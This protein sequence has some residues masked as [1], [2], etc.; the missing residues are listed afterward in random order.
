MPSDSTPR[1]LVVV[2]PGFSSLSICKWQP[3]LDRLKK[4]QEY[5]NAHFF[6]SDHGNLSRIGLGTLETLAVTLRARIDQEW[7]SNDFD[8]LVIIG[9]SMGGTIARQAYLMASGSVQ[10]CHTSQWAN[11]VVRIV[12][13]ASINRGIDLNPWD[14]RAARW[15]WSKYPLAFSAW[16]LRICQ[17]RHLFLL[18]D[19]LRGSA[20]ITNLRINWIRHTIQGSASQRQPHLVQVLG[21][22]DSLVTRSD[23]Q[24]ILA[25]PNCGW[26]DVADANHT[27][28]YS[29]SDSKNP[30]GRYNLLRQAFLGDPPNQ[31]STFTSK[32]EVKRLVFILHGIRDNN[33]ARWNKDLADTINKLSSGNVKV[34]S[35]TYNYLSAARFA[36]PTTRKKYIP[37]FQDWYTE[38][39]AA[40]PNASIGVIAHSNGTYILA[41]SL[42]EVS[43]LTVNDVFLAGSVLPQ[44]F[45]WDFIIGVKKQCQRVWNNRSV[46]DIPVGYLCNLLRGMLMLDIGTGGYSGFSSLY[47][48]ETA[49][50]EGGHSAAIDPQ[51]YNRIAEFAMGGDLLEPTELLELDPLFNRGSL[52]MPYVGGFAA[53]AVLSF[54]GWLGFNGMVFYLIACLLV[55]FGIFVR[56]DVE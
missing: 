3:L 32:S 35:P 34:F 50:Y 5:L 20:F 18:Q 24:D 38:A 51:H 4:E 33:V 8:E 15:N 43:S 11:A 29:L 42:S 40:H 6:F 31:L 1:R 7:A 2:V 12:L 41:H 55:A 9:H 14:L 23:S 28:V 44:T 52:F 54:L 48:Q 37:V 22:L 47:V 46:A 27:N 21:T 13:F 26:I 19:L 17:F 53:I 45:D 30:E 25:F 39:I 10:G 36:V 49:Y 56:L 16:I